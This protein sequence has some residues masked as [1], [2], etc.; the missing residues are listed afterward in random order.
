MN[1]QIRREILLERVQ[2]QTRLAV[3]EDR[4]LCEVQYERGARSKLQGNVY[5][6]RVQNVLPGMN[7]AF[8]DIGLGKNAFLCAGDI[9]YDTRDQQEL[10]NQLEGARIEKLLRPG[11]MIVV[12]VSK[13]PGG[14]KGPRVCEN[15]T[16]PGRL[17]VLLPTV[18]YAGVSKKIPEGP[19]RARLLG[20][21]QRLSQACGR[22][23]IVR[24]AG[25]G[26]TEAEI[27]ADC[28]RL[29]GLWAQ[30]ER[31][32]GHSA[33]P[34][35]IQADGSLALR[36]VRDM[37]DE[38]VAAVRTDDEEIYAQLRAYAEALTPQLADRIELFAGDAPLFDLMRVD[39]QIEQA[40]ERHVWLKSGGTL[41]IDETEALT[42]I[43]VNT[44]K[45]TGKRD[46][47]ETIFRLNCEAAEEIARQLRLRDLGGIV[48]I[49]FIDMQSQEARDALLEQLKQCLRRDR[50][51]VNVLGMTALG[52][53]EMTRKKARQPL[54]RQLMRDCS[55]CLGTGREWTHESVAYRAVREIWRKRRMGDVTSYCVRTGGKV[56]ALIDAIGFPGGG[57]TK[58][59]PTGEEENYE[60]LPMGSGGA[61]LPAGSEEE[62]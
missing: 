41:V 36:A 12:Q 6:A 45:F 16:L 31:R 2:N 32:A 59:D 44:A 21:A 5:A 55:A 26:A 57:E 47:E 30:I 22:G 20:I 61:H 27:S 3:I 9:C 43:D 13:E 8:V 38:S 49:D 14:S 52:L 11:Q 53:V 29:V 37:L 23:V 39:R 1:P 7:A 10:R 54:S 19:E 42:V 51:H 48:L 60:I 24:T 62:L 15:I 58:C 35:L 34:Q 40:M 46:L 28:D 17:A 50:N 33:Q 25:E 4:R 18:R 56:A